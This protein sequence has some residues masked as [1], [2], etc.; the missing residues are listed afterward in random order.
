MRYIV[1]PEIHLIGLDEVNDYM[2]FPTNT[3]NEKKQKNS[4]N[5]THLLY[6]TT[7]STVESKFSFINKF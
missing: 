5:K 6:F 1:V 2:K 4:F 7:L 3:K